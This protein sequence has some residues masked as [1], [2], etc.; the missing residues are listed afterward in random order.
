MRY[1]IVLVLC[2]CTLTPNEMRES[3]PRVDFESAYPALKAA[4]CLARNAEESR[5]DPL[6]TL[7]AQW[8]ESRSPGS[9]EVTIRPREG[10]LGVLAD[11]TPSA[12]GSRV[13]IWYHPVQPGLWELVV[14]D[15]RKGC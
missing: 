5:P 11:I 8:R 6:V 7:A 14:Q 15:M 3:A 10:F 2:G 1:L 13:S 9:Y 12:S 4:Q